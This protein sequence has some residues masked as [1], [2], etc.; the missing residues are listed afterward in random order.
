MFNKL[1]NKIERMGGKIILEAQ[2]ENVKLISNNI[3]SVTYTKVNKNFTIDTDFV[4]NALSLPLFIKLL[5]KTVPFS[6]RQHASKLN[7]ISLILI[8]I[9]FS[10]EKIGKD[11]WF[12]LL[13]NEF[14]SNRVTEQK[15]ISPFTMKKGKTVLSFE[16]TCRTTDKLWKKTDRE[17]Y[18]IVLEDCKQVPLLNKNI[19]HITNYTIHFTCVYECLQKF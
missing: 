7:Y 3:K 6:I 19:K 11:N 12:Y 2:V 16:L 13:D 15:N 4:V 9:E 8:Y 10:V 14:S 18:E 5:D 1:A 17:L